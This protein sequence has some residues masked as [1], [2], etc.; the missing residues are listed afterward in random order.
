[1][2]REEITKSNINITAPHNRPP[3]PAS[4]VVFSCVY[5]S[6]NGERNGDKKIAFCFFCIFC[7]SVRGAEGVGGG[8]G[9]GMGWQEA[10]HWCGFL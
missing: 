8:R 7:V 6:K 9:W 1:M 2:K 10:V 3:H 5:A 4:L